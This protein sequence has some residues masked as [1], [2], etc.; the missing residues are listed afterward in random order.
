MKKQGQP[1]LKLALGVIATMVSLV[2]GL[3]ISTAKASYDS[4][5]TQLT[6][7]AADAK[8]IDGSL[9]LYGSDAK[10]AQEALRDLLLSFIDQMQV[11][12]ED[13]SVHTSSVTKT[14]T[15]NFYR[16]VRRL[17]PHDEEQKSHAKG[18]NS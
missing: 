2:L 10:D 11:F 5:W 9:A 16:E 6:Q 1:E 8:L 7:I 12:R 15:K 4:R 17:L 3:L 18:T 14:G 13:R